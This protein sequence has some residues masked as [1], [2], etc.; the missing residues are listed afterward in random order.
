MLFE[1]GVL[2]T[3]S[4]PANRKKYIEIE[5]R[6]REFSNEIGINMDEMDLA[7]WSYKTGVILK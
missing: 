6:L 1:L 4:K 2:P 5:D 3:N 7:L